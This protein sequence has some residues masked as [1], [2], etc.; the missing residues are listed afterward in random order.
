MKVPSTSKQLRVLCEAIALLSGEKNE[1]KCVEIV[2]DSIERLNFSRNIRIRI[3]LFVD[4]NT[5]L[6][7]YGRGNYGDLK[8]GDIRY[9]L[10]D[11]KIS[12]QS[13]RLKYPW[14]HNNIHNSR[15]ARS[16]DSKKNQIKSFL[17]IPLIEGQEKLL[18]GAISFDSTEE[19]EFSSDHFQVLEPYANLLVDIISTSNKSNDNIISFISRF[20]IRNV[21]VLGKD[22]GNELKRLIA[23]CDFLKTKKYTPILVKDQPDI[24]ELSNEEKV[25]VFADTSRFVIIENSFPAGQIAECKICS[26]NRIITA[27]LREKGKGSSFMVTDYFKDFNFMHEF[28]YN[29]TIDSLQE[30]IANA[31]IWAED[32]IKERIEYY[33]QIYPSRNVSK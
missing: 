23:I 30:S 21:L 13:I 31:I 20:K 10:S 9:T 12:D 16:K 26:T 17:S 7:K 15:W 8:F 22:T 33:N 4:Y 6:L 14:V 3:S 28:E 2:F 1:D 11:D 25:R 5:L 27:T 19:N 29:D 24:P 18:L 32:R